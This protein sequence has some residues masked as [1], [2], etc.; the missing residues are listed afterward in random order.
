MRAFV[1]ALSLSLVGLCACEAPLV[2]TDLGRLEL[3]LTNP[4]LLEE[5]N[6]LVALMF[7]N[8]GG[9]ASCAAL[10]NATPNALKAREPAAVQALSKDEPACRGTGGAH[11]FGRVDP[12]G[13]YTFVLLG[14]VRPFCEI[15]TEDAEVSALDAVRGTVI[16]VGCEELEVQWNERYDI[17]LALFPAGLR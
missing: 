11:T 1:V 12:A 7:A 3:G 14:S 10:V 2:E 17:Q 13:P 8:E 9:N 6:T 15:E 4:T 16:A 5:V